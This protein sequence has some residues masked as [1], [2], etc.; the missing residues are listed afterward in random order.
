MGD[1]N[2]VASIGEYPANADAQ[3]ARRNRARISTG[4]AVCCA[5]GLILVTI[6]LLSPGGALGY[7]AYYGAVALAVGWSWGA[8]WRRDG[9]VGI[10][11]LLALGITA[12]G[13]ADASY[14]LN[15]WRTGQY[16]D[17]SMADIGWMVAYVFVAA[18]V[19]LL[20]R[21]THRGKAR[22]VDAVLDMLFTFVVAGLVAWTLWVSPAV[23]D[24]TQPVIARLV[25]AAYPVLDVALLG[26][27]VRALATR[28]ATPKG[29]WP[30]AA[31]SAC[32]L[33]SDI[34]Y[35]VTGGEG[36][37]V[38]A[39]SAG[40]M[41]A[42]L[43]LAAGAWAVNGQ[44]ASEWTDER[45]VIVSAS[46]RRTALTIST[47]AVPWVFELSSYLTGRDINPIPL[48]VASILLAILTYAR[49][50]HLIG[51]LGHTGAEHAASE[52]RFRALAANSSDAVVVLDPLGRVT[53]GSTHLHTLLDRTEPVTDGTNLVELTEQTSECS[54]VLRGLLVRSLKA[55]GQVIDGEF[56]TLRADG[57]RQWLAG[58]IV[59]LL[60]DPDIG[61]IVLN[62][63]DVSDRKRAEQEL[64]HNAFHD[65]LTGLANRSLL[66]DRLD[67]AVDQAAR[68]GLDP[69]VLY[70][71]LDGFKAINDTLGHAAGDEVL[72][73]T[74]HRIGRSLRSGD[75]LAR[76]GGDE[77]IV[78]IEQ[79]T[80]TVADA[81]A[82]S[83]RILADVSEPM[84][85]G[86]E[87]VSLSASIGIA[88][89]FLG[90]PAPELMRN[91]DIAMYQ[92]KSMGP[93]RAVIYEPAMGDAA[94]RHFQI[95]KDL[96]RA[97]AQGELRVEYQPV[98]RLNSR[99]IHGAE[100]LLRWDHP[101]LG[102]VPPDVFIPI[103]ERNGCIV[104][105]GK[106]VLET[107]CGQCQEWK[108][109]LGLPPSFSIAV[110]A[111]A[112]QLNSPTFF[113]DVTGAIEASGLDPKALVVE[114]TETT[115]VEHPAAASDVLERLRS[116]GIRVAIDDFG[117]GYSS[118]SYLQNMPI[119]ILKIDRSFVDSIR[120]NA[121]VPDVVR[122][123]VQLARTLQ[124]ATV[125]EG[126]E[127]VEQLES[128]RQLHCEEGQGFLFSRPLRPTDLA[129]VLAEQSA[130]EPALRT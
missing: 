112:R 73:E 37:T 76:V 34:A 97:L 36:P 128:L 33:A 54:A 39:Q 63:H 24:G 8:V 20:L 19:V 51:L 2:T 46:R 79:S 96:H 126:I 38:A 88:E 120:A 122:G 100:A 1:T 68:T 118:L 42:A 21:R 80:A 57:V 111:S 75:T 4:T 53:Q 25:T 64:V 43:F 98:V 49:F 27:L 32:W 74:A 35:L 41:A 40:W 69:S 72:R 105:I 28:G 94:T 60:A 87:T 84:Q 95:D 7:G 85:I 30:I 99:E 55:P 59:N 102:L 26:L 11:A 82:I 110:N 48:L 89:G 104:D 86:V 113:D 93:G 16:P 90:V 56:C 116:L 52:R 62:L 17:I 14:D 45:P 123:V 117:T 77:F 129:A 106:W 119:D 58:R 124:L 23:T 29:L 91:S 92:A 83:V 31:G 121:A 81:Q 125:A 44:P 108:R 6:E 71:D 61:G 78:V 109:D 130:A 103:A 127:T 22:D 65:P 107:A 18:A 101:T 67:H 10:S 66:L 12:T 9:A 50:A 115:L 114:I 3:P 70:I 15:A 5:L 13:L 47:L